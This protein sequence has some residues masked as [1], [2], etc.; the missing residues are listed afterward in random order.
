MPL[1]QVYISPTPKHPG[2]SQYLPMPVLR[3]LLCWL[4]DLKQPRGY[5]LKLR[6]EAQPRLAW[7]SPGAVG[8]AAPPRLRRFWPLSPCSAVSLSPPAAGRPPRRRG[9]CLPLPAA[10]HPPLS[11]PLPGASSS[12]V[13]GP[14]APR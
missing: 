12:G 8:H 9:V 11:L 14:S 13:C 1:G 4:W 7:E 3:A 5:V 2:L 10:G 6:L